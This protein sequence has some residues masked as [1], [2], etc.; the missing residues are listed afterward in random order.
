VAEIEGLEIPEHPVL[1]VPRATGRGP[2]E[3]AT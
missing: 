2:H 1:I 3:H